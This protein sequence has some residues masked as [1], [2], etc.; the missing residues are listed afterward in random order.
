M[1]L[2]GRRVGLLV[3]ECWWVSFPSDLRYQI[4]VDTR[5]RAVE[6]PSHDLYVNFC[7]FSAPYLHPQAEYYIGGKM[8]RDF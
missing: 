3:S 1:G 5:V 6:Q 4:T 8:W 7:F 2:V